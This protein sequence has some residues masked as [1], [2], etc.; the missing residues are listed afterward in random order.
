MASTVLENRQGERIMQQV[1]RIAT[2]LGLA[3]GM[4]TIQAEVA[5]ASSQSLGAAVEEKRIAVYVDGE[6]FTA[7]E[8]GD[9]HKYPF[10]YPVAGPATGK[11]V[12]TWDQEPYPHQ[13][14]LFI[15]LDWVRSEGVNRGNYW[16]ARHELETGHVLS[17]SPRILEATGDKVVL[18]DICE[19]TVPQVGVTQ[20][21]D[22][23]TV[24]IT[25]PSPTIRI[26]DFQFEFEILEDLEV[27]P[28]GHSLF[29]AR[30]QPALAVGDP[31]RGPEQAPLGTGTIVDADGGIDEEGTRENTAAWCAYYG[32]HHGETEGVAI[33]QHPD[34]PMS[35]APWF[36]RDYGFMS[37]TPFDFRGRISLEK[38]TELTF[39]YRTIVFSGDHEEADIATWAEAFMEAR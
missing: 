32:Q 3:I 26:L 14:S 1:T 36:N 10:F 27:G 4:A 30:M 35:P 5:G 16:Q 24:T 25:A 23:R 33:V 9:H 34:N 7:Y 2:A 12:T 38:G 22:T 31:V 20:L 37:P 15:S 39:R 8:F 17:R 18:Q 21:R 29:S 13:S 28:T 11:S 19:W 6:L